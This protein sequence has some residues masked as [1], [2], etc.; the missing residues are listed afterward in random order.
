[1]SWQCSTYQ[2]KVHRTVADFP[3]MGSVM[4]TRLKERCIQQR[5]DVGTWLE[6]RPKK[7]LQNWLSYNPTKEKLYA[8]LCFQAW[9]E[10]VLLHM[11]W[12]ICVYMCGRQVGCYCVYAHTDF[13]HNSMNCFVSCDVLAYCY[14]IVHLIKCWYWIIPMCAHTHRLHG[15]ESLLRSL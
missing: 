11:F 14:F 5:L 15:V 12:G 3:G 8:V 10:N 1:M 13:W 2:S 9:R 7:L 4:A 6:A